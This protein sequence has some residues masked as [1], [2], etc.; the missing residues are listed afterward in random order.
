M[1]AVAA[2]VALQIPLA[3][4]V[5]VDAKRLGLANPAMY[6]LGILVPTAGLAVAFVYFSRRREL[7]RADDASE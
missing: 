1:L 6:E 3:I 7:P 2:V 4:V 5:H